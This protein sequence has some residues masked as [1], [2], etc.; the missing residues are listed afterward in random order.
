MGNQSHVLPGI[1]NNNK[2]CIRVSN[3]VSIGMNPKFTTTAAKRQTGTHWKNLKAFTA[4][5]REENKSFKSSSLTEELRDEDETHKELLDHGKRIC[6]SALPNMET[7]LT[8]CWRGA[9]W[10]MEGRCCWS[11]SSRVFWSGGGQ[12]LRSPASAPA[13]LGPPL[14]GAAAPLDVWTTSLV[15]RCHGDAGRSDDSSLMGK[16]FWKRTREDC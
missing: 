13:P 8:E 9:K 14:P 6:E 2:T 11:F 16:R 3:G 15:S 4:N 5:P 7:G 10:P 12:S 1:P